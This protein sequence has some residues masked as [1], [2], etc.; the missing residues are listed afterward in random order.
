MKIT[1]KQDYGGYG[2]APGSW[3]PF[4]F[5]QGQTTDVTDFLGNKWIAEGIATP[6]TEA[7]ER[8]A[9]VSVPEIQAMRP[10]EN[11]MTPI[12]RRGRP[13]GSQNKRR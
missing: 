7:P 12:A 2:L 11:T 1:F 9:K 4:E 8:P 5:L 10:P 3:E 6:Y 13:K